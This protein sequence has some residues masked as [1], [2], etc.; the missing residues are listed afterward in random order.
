MTLKIECPEYFADVEMFA[1]DNEC[2]EALLT[3]FQRLRNMCKEDEVVYLHKDF[4]PLSFAFLLTDGKRNRLV[5]GL[6]YSGP[7]QV[8]NGG[9][10]TF[11]VSVEPHT[12]E[13]KW[14]VHT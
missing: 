3:G 6:I 11:T 13:H 5:G 14:S 7:G 2:S 1:H 8:L 4:A 9:A 10:P 12:G